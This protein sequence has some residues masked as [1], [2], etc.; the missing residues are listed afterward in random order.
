MIGTVLLVSWPR[1]VDIEPALERACHRAVAK[2]TPFDLREF[3]TLDYLEDHSE[4]G[5]A[6][7][8]LETRFASNR[9]AKVTW[10]CRVNPKNSRVFR[11]KVGETQGTHKLKAATVPFKPR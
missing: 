1:L 3:T 5:I 9:W 8:R 2:S 10:T 11:A 4:L 6:H 7:G